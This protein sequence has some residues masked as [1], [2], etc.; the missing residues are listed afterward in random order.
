[1]CFLFG[2]TACVTISGRVSLEF[3]RVVSGTSCGE[4]FILVR[5]V[6]MSMGRARVV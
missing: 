5:C 4:F 3:S 2:A 6:V 1:M